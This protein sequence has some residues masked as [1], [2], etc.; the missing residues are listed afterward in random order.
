M[1]RIELWTTLPLDVSNQR[2]LPRVIFSKYTGN[3]FFPL[4]SSLM[5]L[6]PP[7]L[8]FFLSKLWISYWDF[9]RR[10]FWCKIHIFICPRSWDPEFIRF[11]V[12][13]G[14]KRQK[15]SGFFGGSVKSDLVFMDTSVK[16]GLKMK[17]LKHTISIRVEKCYER[18][19]VRGIKLDSS[20]KNFFA[21]Y[22]E[23]ITRG[24]FLWLQTSSGK[25]VHHSI[26]HIFTFKIFDLSS[27]VQLQSHVF[28]RCRFRKIRKRAKN[29]FFPVFQKKRLMKFHTEQFVVKFMIVYSILHI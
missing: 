12:F 20:K 7:L 22:F 25:V 9:S 1:C 15:A 5:P 8:Y 13:S 10:I 23:K 27:M 16:T 2:N 14:R 11:M 6:I 24:K 21:S 18:A 17:G 28:C 19:R 3:K 26:L 4:E 29:G